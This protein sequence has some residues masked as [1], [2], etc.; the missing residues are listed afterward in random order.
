MALPPSANCHLKYWR[1]VAVVASCTMPDV[2]A[3]AVA[4]AP[5]VAP[6][7]AAHVEPLAESSML[8]VTVPAPVIDRM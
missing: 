8:A 6:D 5:V 1:T 7:N 4:I 2:G 3:L